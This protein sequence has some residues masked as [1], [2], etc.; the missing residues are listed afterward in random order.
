VPGGRLPAG[1]RDGRTVDVPL[2]ARRLVAVEVRV[3]DTDSKHSSLSPSHKTS[4]GTLLRSHREYWT[5]PWTALTTPRW[6]ISSRVLRLRTSY[7]RSEGP[8]LVRRIR[9]PAPGERVFESAVL[10]D[11]QCCGRVFFRARHFFLPPK[12]KRRRRRAPAARNA[13]HS[14]A[15]RAGQLTSGP[16]G[17][18]LTAIHDTAPR[19]KARSSFKSGLNGGKGLFPRVIEG[20]DST[21]WFPTWQLYVHPALGT[22]LSRLLRLVKDQT[23]GQSGRGRYQYH[24]GSCEPQSNG[25]PAGSGHPVKI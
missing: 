24:Q 3:V 10:I 16:L 8:E 21:T 20:C 14:F 11:Y 25:R 12:S 6:S 13:S 17:D 18:F 22:R 15:P 7:H 19:R 9:P 5:S 4:P 23:R 2:E 1:D